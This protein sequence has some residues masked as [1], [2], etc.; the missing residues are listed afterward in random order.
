MWAFAYG[1]EHGEGLQH[2]RAWFAPTNWP[3]YAAWWVDDDEFP[4]IA[5]ALT[6]ALHLS[7]H[8][9]TP[10]A[11]DFRVAYTPDGQPYTLDRTRALAQRRAISSVK[12][13][14]R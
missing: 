8:G 6:R 5:D 4:S 12:A 10:Y 11:F 14:S 3:A 7:Q 9:P 13:E 1:G 2:R